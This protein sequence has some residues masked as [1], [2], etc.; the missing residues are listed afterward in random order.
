MKSKLITFAI[1]ILIQQV[2]LVRFKRGSVG[3]AWPTNRIPYAFSNRIDFD[4]EARSEI[5][6]ILWQMQNMLKVNG[7]KCIEFVPRDNEPDYI[8]FIDNGDCSS[9]VGFSKGTNRISL[10][11]DCI[12]T[13]VVM[14]EMMHR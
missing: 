11:K 10:S 9:S 5:E 4:V 1:L 12:T 14:H 13:E 3:P 2:E 7:V 6:H 8:L